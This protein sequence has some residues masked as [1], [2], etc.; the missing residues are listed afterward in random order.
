MTLIDILIAALILFV[1]IYIAKLLLDYLEL[2]P[3]VRSI[4]MLIIA[5]VV[6]IVIL[7]WFGVGTGDLTL[8]GSR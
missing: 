8:G 3:P 2:P 4:A 5:I 6:L 1:V 7:S